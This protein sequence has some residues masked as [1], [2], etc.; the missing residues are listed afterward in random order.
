[1]FI[2]KFPSLSRDLLHGAQRGAS[3]NVQAVAQSIYSTKNDVR[4]EGKFRANSSEGSWPSRGMYK[5]TKGS[6][7]IGF[8]SSR[9]KW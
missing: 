8:T 7:R 9:R 4:S 6:R 3:L 2:V 1:M 5:A